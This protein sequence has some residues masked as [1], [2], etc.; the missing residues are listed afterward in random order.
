MVPYHMVLPHHTKW[1]GGTYTYHT[2]LWYHASFCLSNVKGQRYSIIVQMSIYANMSLFVKNNC[3][4][5]EIIVVVV[6]DCFALT[7]HSQ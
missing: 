6:S 3:E 4:H 1:Y 2:I 5:G 7:Y